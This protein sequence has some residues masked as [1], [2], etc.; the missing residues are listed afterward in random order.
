VF[1]LERVGLR[2]HSVTDLTAHIK[3]LLEGDPDLG[4]VWVEGEV[5]N[6]RQVGSGHWYW[7][8]KDAASTVR[9]VMW[10]GLAALQSHRAEDGAR[11]VVHGQV[12]VY[13]AQGQYQLIVDHLEPVGQGD[14]YRAFER[15]KAALEAEGL[16]DR[17]RK[18]PLPAY[19]RRIGV[20]TSADAAALR[21]ICRVLARRWPGVEVCV[22]P[23]PV[24]GEAAPAGITAAL[25]AVGRAGVDVVIVARG[26]GSIEDLWAFN[27]EGVARAIAA[28][29]VPVVSGVGHETDFT[30]ADFVAD[31]RAPT[32]S[33]AAELVTP[34][35]RE[36]A[37]TVDELR[38]R[39]A[40]RLGQDLGRRGADVASARRRLA[41]GSPA[42]V[43]GDRR[44]AVADRRARC[45]R[46]VE[47]RANLARAGL[48]GTARRLAALSPA[49]T[50]ERG[51]SH[52]SRR[53]DGATVRRTTDVTPGAAVVVRVADGRFGAAVEGQGRLFAPGEGER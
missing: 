32:P 43:L 11:L 36:L 5:S 26:G 33:A 15:L 34:D 7:S 46:A 8:L 18:R 27:D 28:C 6:C 49:A 20:V 23:T 1:D 30:I 13:A 14:L 31:V 12:S 17:A 50:L 38:E 9:C 41:I 16:F 39:L 48:D 24:Q 47:G 45:M 40:R 22:A 44:A 10:K 53:S 4:D 21:D 35:G 37:M 19:P 3:T 25:L 42:R 52:V 29:P 51:Y 2:I